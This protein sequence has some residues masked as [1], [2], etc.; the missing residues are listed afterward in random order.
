MKLLF[1]HNLS[2]RLVARL[3][4]LFPDASHVSLVGL[5]QASDL[6]VW[7]FA[8]V[9]EFTLVTKD[10]DFDDLS[11]LRGFPPKVIWLR[12]GNCTT[13]QIEQVLRLHH[14]VIVDFGND[15]TAGVLVIT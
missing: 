8:G 4:D 14:P 6:I 10:S 9:K 13:Q 5:D 12:I 11:L 3:F 7:H 1:D 2:P 15:P